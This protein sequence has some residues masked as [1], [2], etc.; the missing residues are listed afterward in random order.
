[1][2]VRYIS[3]RNLPDKAI[4]LIDEA[5]SRV[6]LKSLTAPPDLK[7]LE[8]QADKLS[9]EKEEAVRSRIL[10]MRQMCVM[11]KRCSTTIETA[12]KTGKA[13]CQN[14]R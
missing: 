7:K 5:A 6:R 9:K 4:D 14:D 12:R 13:T 1:M 2:S 8:D 11:K 10:K 3:D